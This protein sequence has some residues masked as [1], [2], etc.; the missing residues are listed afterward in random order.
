MNP[1]KNYENV[2]ELVMRGIVQLFIEYKDYFRFPIDHREDS[3]DEL[4]GTV[5]S[6]RHSKDC[7]LLKHINMDEEFEI[8]KSGIEEMNG[9]TIRTCE[10]N[11]SEFEGKPYK[12]VFI[13]VTVDDVDE[14]WNKPILFTYGSITPE[15]EEILRGFDVEYYNIRNHFVIRDEQI[16]N[17]FKTKIQDEVSRY[18]G[19][20]NEDKRHLKS[21]LSTSYIF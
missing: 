3:L 12:S 11:E 7:I 18:S 10:E 15:F 1:Q 19:M 8:I 16:T 6:N 5:L 14:S 9:F 4:T 13:E 2:D 17:E 20:F 21:N